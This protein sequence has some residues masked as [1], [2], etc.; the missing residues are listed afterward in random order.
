MGKLMD[1]EAGAMVHQVPIRVSMQSHHHQ[2]WMLGDV[3]GLEAGVAE[4]EA[5]QEA[6]A[7]SYT[8][9][10]LSVQKIPGDLSWMTWIDLR[11]HRSQIHES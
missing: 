3:E 2:A 6:V 4:G 7:V 8:Y 5:C 1:L 9:S 11:R 10:R